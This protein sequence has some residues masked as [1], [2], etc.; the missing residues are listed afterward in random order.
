MRNHEPVTLRLK[1]PDDADALGAMLEACSEQ[2]YHFFHPYRLTRETGRKVA[3]DAGIH[4]IVAVVSTGEIAGYVWFALGD[5]AMPSIGIVVADPWHERGIGRALMEGIIA[6]AKSQGKKGL[7]LT[8]MADNPRALA[9]YRRVGFV[10]DGDANDPFG[11]S[12][13]MTLRFD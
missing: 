12:Y 13:H 1:T 10:V 6:A 5:D 4:C 2:T 9:L 8:V 3:A 7:V 11:P